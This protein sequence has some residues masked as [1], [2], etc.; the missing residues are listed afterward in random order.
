MNASGA[1]IPNT[2]CDD[3][4]CTTTTASTWTNTLTY[5]FGYRCDDVSGTNCPSSFTANKFKQFADNSKSQTPIA[6]MQGT[7]VGRSLQSTITY[8]VNVSATQVAG[9][10]SNVITYVAT[11][12]F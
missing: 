3:G 7:N 9:L 11:P 10:Y 1:L 6:V 12:T 8:K 5:G 2:T 4:A